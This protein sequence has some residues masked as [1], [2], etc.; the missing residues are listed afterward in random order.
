MAGQ[1]PY[2]NG[3]TSATSSNSGGPPGILLGDPIFSNVHDAFQLGCEDEGGTDQR[4]HTSRGH[5]LE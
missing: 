1:A 5:Q 4:L 3:T 2:Q